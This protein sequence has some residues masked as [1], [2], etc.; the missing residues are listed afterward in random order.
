MAVLYLINPL[1]M[2]ILPVSN[3]YY[4][5]SFMMNNLIADALCTLLIMKACY[6]HVEL[7]SQPD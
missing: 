4:C 7:S 3:V 5:N 1:F 2:D 6:F